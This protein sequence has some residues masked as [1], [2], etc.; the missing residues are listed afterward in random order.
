MDNRRIAVTGIGAITPIGN[1]VSAVWDSMV[2]GRCGIDRIT[3]FDT[4]DFK[5]KCA[6]EVRDF[7]PRDYLEKQEILRTD[8]F[9]QYAIAAAEE[10]VRES[11]IIGS[12]E[13][14]RFAVYFGTGI[15]GISTFSS[16][17]EKMMQ[18]GPGR[19]SP[20]FVPMMIANMASGMLAIRYK[21][22][23]PALPAVTA[24]AS[25]SNA[26]G[27]A[28]RLIR[29]GYA[30]AVITGGTEASITPIGI[31]GFVNMQ[32]LSQASDPA[33]ASL[34]FDRRR[35]GFVIAEGAAALILEEYG[36]AERRGAH[37]YAE[38]TG[39]GST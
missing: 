22:K 25:G 24:C 23:G 8:L 39:Y 1:S 30:D 4:S 9:T 28:V 36:M 13:P 12:V 14:E 15:G 18:R 2:S 10:A 6:G 16:E 38:I 21:A 7:N 33:A 35:S 5:A 31:A 19:V 26:I 34:P 32:A 11:G 27:E 17:M 37:I 20:Y 29:H 3:R